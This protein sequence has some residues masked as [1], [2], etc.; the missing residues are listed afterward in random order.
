MYVR[1]EKC[2]PSQSGN[3]HS[4]S[5]NAVLLLWVCSGKNPLIEVLQ[6]YLFR[7]D[8]VIFKTMAYAMKQLYELL[9]W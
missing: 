2:K 6:E 8:F 4:R 3:G 9:F 1:V 7:S 5:K